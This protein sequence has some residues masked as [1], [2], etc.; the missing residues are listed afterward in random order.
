MA[1][2]RQ[3]IPPLNGKCQDKRLHG[4]VMAERG[5]KLFEA[6]HA[7]DV[8]CWNVVREKLTPGYGLLAC[9]CRRIVVKYTV[10]RAFWASLS[11][12]HRA[13]TKPYDVL[14]LSGNSGCPRMS[15]IFAAMSAKPLPVRIL[16]WIGHI[17][18]LCN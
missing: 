17:A 5:P 10:V 3:Y 12:I 18:I 16:P 11:F 4:S 8:M 2:A 13:M 15:E 6:A 9:V 1:Q 14:P 7:N